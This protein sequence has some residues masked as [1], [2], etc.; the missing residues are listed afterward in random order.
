M[1]CYH[2]LLEGIN[3]LIC[4]VYFDFIHFFRCKD[5]HYDLNLN[6]FVEFYNNKNGQ[7]QPTTRSS[8]DCFKLKPQRYKTEP[9]MVFGFN[10][11]VPPYLQGWGFLQSHFAQNFGSAGTC[12]WSSTCRYSNCKL[13]G[14][15]GVFFYYYYYFSKL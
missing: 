6:N 14:E 13:I 11:I 4:M 5:G 1:F 2:S 10:C 15:G 7:D 3:S 8:K 9:H 12:S